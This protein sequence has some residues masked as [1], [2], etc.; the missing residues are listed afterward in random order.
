MPVVPPYKVLLCLNP[1]CHDEFYLPLD[2]DSH[3]TCPHDSSHPVAVYHGPTL[4]AG[5]EGRIR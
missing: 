3:M 5:V 2:P 1:D 4:H